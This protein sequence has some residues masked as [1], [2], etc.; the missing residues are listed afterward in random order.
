MEGKE[1]NGAAA[2]ATAPPVTEKPTEGLSKGVLEKPA[3][4]A[5]ESAATAPAVTANGEQAREQKKDDADVEMKEAAAETV[6][7]DGVA[8]PVV[9]TDNRDDNSS[10]NKRKAE[11]A[12]S[13]DADA[14]AEAGGEQKKAKTNAETETE[15]GTA[16]AATAAPTEAETDQAKQANGN[17]KTVPPPE[18]GM[19]AAP[20]APAKRPGRPRK[21][22][23]PQPAVGRTQRKTRSQGPVEA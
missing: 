6:T 16:P 3:E 4:K 9:G 23:K 1:T 14:D 8:A 12:F 19:D 22:S 15:P 17:A 21:Q 13:G 11:D 2:M 7:E 5:T 18:T 20:P 10:S